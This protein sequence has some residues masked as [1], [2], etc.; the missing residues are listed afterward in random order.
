MKVNKK[1]IKKSF[2]FMFDCYFVY[3]F[4]NI[5]VAFF[6]SQPTN[7]SPLSHDENSKKAHNLPKT[8]YEF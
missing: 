1:E 8:S 3:D 2:V 6:G 7:F 5:S 4:P